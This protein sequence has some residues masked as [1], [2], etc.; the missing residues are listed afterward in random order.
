M[1][2][3]NYLI[4]SL[5]IINC[6][7]MFI[8][9]IS[10][11][12]EINV[13]I[14]MAHENPRTRFNNPVIVAGIWHN[15][16]VTLDDQNFQNII[17]KFY[18]GS[19]MPSESSRDESNY[20]EWK[21][22]KISSDWIDVKKYQGYSYINIEESEKKDNVYCFCV[23]VK[24]NFP[25][26][27]DYYENWTLMIYK[28]SN[29]IY[30]K[31]IVL[32][33]PMVGLGK[34]RDDKLYFQ[35]TPFSTAQGIQADDDMYFTIE[36]V[37]NVPLEIVVDYGIYNDITS[38]TNSG[39]ILSNQ[40]TFKHEVTVDSKAWKPGIL[41]ITGD[42]LGTIPNNLIITTATI[43]FNTSLQINAAVLEISVGRSNYKIE[44]IPGSNI[45]FQYQK[46]LQMNE[47]EIRDITVY[48][49]GEGTV[50]LKV[51]DD[52]VNVEIL[53]I[54][55]RD[56]TQTPLT[57]ASTDILEYP[58]TI[59]VKALRENKVGT[60]TYNLEVDGKT[61]TYSTRISIG[62]PLKANTQELHL[63]ISTIFV[64][65]CIIIVIVYMVFSQIRHK[66]R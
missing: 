43:T 35:V 58:V 61:T 10:A 52:K 39:L 23:G 64:A 44:P 55:G 48:I 15:V 34:G 27:I 54:N 49:S 46:E 8:P 14:H 17:L 57:I 18:K 5:L 26:I 32:E 38:T 65:I 20:Y 30:S 19:S 29:E 4:I 7:L 63:P 37:G 62:P 31:T 53:K 50:R 2:I 9:S 41:T 45:V 12:N 36:N 42:V 6:I 66:R 13:K 40:K 28:D 16:N 51:V 33:K 59:Q 3:K 22:N 25:E 60:I 56:Q 24:D 21:Y 47:D 11:Q 1:N